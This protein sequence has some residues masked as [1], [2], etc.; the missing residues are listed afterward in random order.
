VR[1]IE[2][3]I[4]GLF[5]YYEP[6]TISL[7]QRGIILIEGEVD[8]NADESNGAGK[9]SIVDAICL[10]LFKE[11]TR[12]T[13]N[14]EVVNDDLDE[15]YA[16]L[17]FETP[18]GLYQATYRR[19]RKRDKTT[20]A[21]YQADTE[22]DEWVAVS[23]KGLT[24]TKEIIQSIIGM[25][26]NT[27]SNSVL[28]AQN[29][30]SVF[31]EGTD[32]TRKDLLTQ[33]LGLDVLDGALKAT[34][35]HLV[36][37]NDQLHTETGKYDL[38]QQQVSSEDSVRRILRDL[39]GQVT[40]RKT[41]ILQVEESIATFDVIERHLEAIR[42][43]DGKIESLR[44]QHAKLRFVFDHDYNDAGR[45]LTKIAND[46]S[47]QKLKL[48]R[49]DRA[50]DDIVRLHEEIAGLEAQ[51]KAFIEYCKEDAIRASELKRI[52]SEIA[53]R[54][55]TIRHLEDDIAD[56]A[57]ECPYCGSELTI[58]GMRQLLEQHEQEIDSL[59][60][61]LGNIQ[62]ERL[63]ASEALG[64]QP[65]DG[66]L[67]EAQ[68]D[69][70]EAKALFQQRTE[71][72]LLISQ[73]Q[74]EE[75]T[76]DSEWK[77]RYP[78][79]NA[80]MDDLSS[81]IEVAK[82]EKGK[83]E[84]TLIDKGTDLNKTREEYELDL[85]DEHARL[86]ELNRQCGGTAR[87]LEE[88]KEAKG[89]LNVVQTEIDAL[90]NEIVH[91]QFLEYMFGP[92]GVK[93]K[94]IQGITPRL[95]D[96]GND[97]LVDLWGESTRI[98]FVT[99][100]QGEKKMIDDFKILITKKTKTKDIRSYSGGERKRLEFAVR[101]PISDI[102]REKAACNAEFLILDEPFDGLSWQ[103]T[104]RVVQL[105]RKLSSRFSTIIVMCHQAKAKELF[106]KT[107]TVRKN[108]DRSQITE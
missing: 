41:A 26:F 56:D 10:C 67:S 66:D 52:Q 14:D 12:G 93:A 68:T 82:G 28:F 96:L 76:L 35:G 88:I 81:Q 40:E 103:G 16:E 106:D 48:E 37:L 4:D 105:L 90:K 91:E 39:E 42:G 33:I 38:L 63:T 97:Y 18:S 15:G 31:I 87:E 77:E 32:K 43:L 84:Q 74:D 6:S 83:I 104:R 57:A 3:K 59:G 70:A 73:L 60:I 19:N 71:T 46:L 55:E 24:E 86:D 27:F 30:V 45:I 92:D 102:V 44:Q 72:V 99:S 34:K 9:S 51:Q 62:K 75:K 69:L 61:Q 21:I 98:E 107:I 25:D 5:S 29:G 85:E 13:K 22:K 108:G 95:T 11:T 1:L 100:Y 80:E 47:L 2:L 36:M 20:W 64:E 8:D 94:I 78:K 58:D 49:I 50:S 17:T 89:K 53:K 7:D 54:K 101:F 79:L 23:G 65:S